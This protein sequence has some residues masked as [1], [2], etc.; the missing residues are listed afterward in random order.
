MLALTDTRLE[1]I[2]TLAAPLHPRWR[3]AFLR[4][5]AAELGDRQVGDGELHHIAL[6]VRQGTMERERAPRRQRTAAVVAIG[7]RP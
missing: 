5:L 1:Q 7:G 3:G 2:K 6:R 4:A